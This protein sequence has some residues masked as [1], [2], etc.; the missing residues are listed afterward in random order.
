M[1][2]ILILK[3][4]FDLFLPQVKNHVINISTSSCLENLSIHI[5]NV[6]QEWYVV[7]IENINNIQNNILNDYAFFN[8]KQILD[9]I[10]GGIYVREI[11]QAIIKS[12]NVVEQSESEPFA[13]PTYREKRDATQDV[14]N[15]PKGTTVDIDYKLSK[16]RYVSGGKIIVANSEFGDYISACVYDKDEVLPEAYRGTNICEAWPVVAEYIEKMFVD[17]VGGCEIDTR[18]LNAKIT[19]GLILRISYTAINFGE[20]RKVAVNYNLTKKL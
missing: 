11:H 20:T 2:Y 8:K 13:K 15:V 6:D 17:L 10:K 14:I 7:E 12:V 1:R 4:D 9:L 16:V 3:S 18:P 5:L 19:V